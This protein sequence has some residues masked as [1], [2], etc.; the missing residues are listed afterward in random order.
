MNA[1]LLGEVPYVPRLSFKPSHSAVS[2][3]SHVAVG[4]SSKAN[5]REDI[6]S[7]TLFLVLVRPQT[8]CF[9]PRAPCFPR[10]PVFSSRPRVIHTPRFSHPE[11][12]RLPEPV[13]LAP[14][15]PAS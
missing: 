1:S 15:F 14:R 11:F 7:Q 13:P 5:D 12:L 8:P 2:E 6:C 3:G 10:D 9:P 4:I